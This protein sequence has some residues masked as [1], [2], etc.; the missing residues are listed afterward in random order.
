MFAQERPDANNQ[1]VFYLQDVESQQSDLASSVDKDEEDSAKLCDSVQ[2][3]YK[4]SFSCGPP[5]VNA[6]QPIYLRTLVSGTLSDLKRL[7]SKITAPMDELSS[8]DLTCLW[9]AQEQYRWQKWHDDMMANSLVDE[10]GAESRPCT[11]VYT[12]SAKT[13]LG[14]DQYRDAYADAFAGHSLRE[15][16]Q[17]F[18]ALAQI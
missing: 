13:V 3:W 14:L 4:G 9:F 11:S 18:L 15:L 1:A 10:I 5:E 12:N 16:E 6:F 17:H 2:S 7:S 8:H